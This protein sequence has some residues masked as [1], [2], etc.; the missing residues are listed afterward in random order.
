M[1]FEMAACWYFEFSDVF[2]FNICYAI[3][4]SLWLHFFKIV[5]FLTA[6][7]GRKPVLH[8]H[9]RLHQNQSNSCG[10]MAI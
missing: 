1:A 7:G 2:D 3:G 4:V 6:D 8:Q 5:Y 9:V 10:D